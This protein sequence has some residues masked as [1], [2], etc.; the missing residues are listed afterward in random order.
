M[1]F[2]MVSVLL[3][4]DNVGLHLLKSNEPNA[5]SSIY[6]TSQFKLIIEL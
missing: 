2:D 4:V 3:Y 1:Q 6:A 5:N